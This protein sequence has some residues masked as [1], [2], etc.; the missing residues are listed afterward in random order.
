M[1]NQSFELSIKKIVT[2]DPRFHAEAY[3]FVRD[4]LSFTSRAGGRARIQPRDVGA[5]ELLDGLRRFALETYGPMA[6]TV[7]AEWGVRGCED[8][9]EIVSNMEAHHCDGQSDAGH[10]EAFKRGYSFEDAFRKPFLPS[11]RCSGSR[12]QVKA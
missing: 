4:A 10:R 3:Y 1:Q 8:F 12:K 2:A 11:N 6:A 7:L 5:S 9:G